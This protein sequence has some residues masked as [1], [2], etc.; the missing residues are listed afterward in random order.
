M[1]F[2]G[3]ETL[4]PSGNVEQRKETPVQTGLVRPAPNPPRSPEIGGISSVDLRFDHKRDERLSISPAMADGARDFGG[5]AAAGLHRG[6]NHAAGR[7]AADSA[8][9]GAVFAGKERIARERLRCRA[10]GN[11]PGRVRERGATKTYGYSN[12]LT[13]YNLERAGLLGKREGGKNYAAI[14]NKLQLVKDVGG[15]NAKEMQ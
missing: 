9:A 7:A 10:E 3:V 2:G 13:L 1:R 4:I 11:H 8:P 15:E 14:R 12:L 5:R 6:A